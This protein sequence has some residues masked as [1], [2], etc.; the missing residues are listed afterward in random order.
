MM[1]R[2][3]YTVRVEEPAATTLRSFDSDLRA[4]FVVVLEELETDPYIN[5]GGVHWRES[6][7]FGA[8][9]DRGYP[10]RV[11][12]AKEIREWR[13]FYYADRKRRVLLIKEIVRREHDDVT[14][15]SGPHVKRLVDNYNRFKLGRRST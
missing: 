14:Y 10:I 2:E 9:R 5:V 3:R 15:G 12:K 1:A 4:V 7:A 6:K 13:V 11:L 8:L